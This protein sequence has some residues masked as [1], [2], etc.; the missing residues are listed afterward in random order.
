MD[1]EVQSTRRWQ[2]ALAFLLFCLAT[3]PVVTQ[4]TS[5]TLF[6]TVLDAQGRVVAGAVVTAQ[7]AA[8]AQQ[9]VATSDPAG[10]FSILG[11]PPGPYELRIEIPGFDADRRTIT[12]TVAQEMRV[13]AVLQPATLRELV[14]VTSEASVIEASHDAGPYHRAR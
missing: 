2:V 14:S 1:E 6:G 10:R 11:L 3:T 4:S 8:T 5:A 12:L 9:R 13:N 7:S